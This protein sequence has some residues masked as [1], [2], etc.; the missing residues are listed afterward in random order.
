M[1][2]IRLQRGKS[3]LIGVPWQPKGLRPSHKKLKKV[4]LGFG[5]F[6]NIGF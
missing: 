4:G 6:Y 1:K 2:N 3:R 5:N